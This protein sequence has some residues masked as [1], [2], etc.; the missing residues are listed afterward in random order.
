VAS[1]GLVVL[2]PV[3]SIADKGTHAPLVWPA[4]PMLASGAG[5]STHCTRRALL[6]QSVERLEHRRL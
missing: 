5:S 1:L 2:Q 3:A 6:R 4:S